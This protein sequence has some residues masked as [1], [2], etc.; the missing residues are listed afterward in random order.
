MVVVC[1]VG[2]LFL[3]SFSLFAM[4]SADAVAVILNSKNAPS[5]RNYEAAKEIVTR[6][7]EAGKPLQ[8]FHH[9]TKE[10]STKEGDE[11]KAPPSF[12]YGSKGRAN[13]CCMVSHLAPWT[14]TEVLNLFP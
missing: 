6:D 2:L 3:T 10:C 9:S 4:S 14:Q 12:L 13:G 11:R 1:A 5:K 7:A 8:Q